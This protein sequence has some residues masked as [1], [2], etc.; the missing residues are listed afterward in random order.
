MQFIRLFIILISC[1]CIACSSTLSEKDRRDK[2]VTGASSLTKKRDAWLAEKPRKFS[3]MLVAQAELPEAL[4]AMGYTDATVDAGYVILTKGNNPKEGVIIFTTVPARPM[5]ILK[6][7]GGQI[8][9]SPYPEI[10][11]LIIERK[12]AE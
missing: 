11:N 4:R 5:P 10:K 6:L 1:A 7:H 12:I 3:M 2:L 9:D 8:T